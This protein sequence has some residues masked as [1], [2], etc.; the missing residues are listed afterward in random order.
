MATFYK[1]LIIFKNSVKRSIYYRARYLVIVEMVYRTWSAK[2]MEDA[3]LHYGSYRTTIP[4]LLRCAQRPS[5]SEGRAHKQ[6]VRCTGAVLDVTVDMRKGSS[7][8]KIVTVVI[9][10]IIVS[11]CTKRIHTWLLY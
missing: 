8:T 4:S 2:A 6:L 3:G 1:I 7:T 11:S 5:L 9:N 10:E